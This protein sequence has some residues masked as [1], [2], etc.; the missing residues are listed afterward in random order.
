MS[1]VLPE[2]G[3]S[4]IKRSLLAQIAQIAVLVFI[5]VIGGM[6]VQ[7]RESRLG[8]LE[9]SQVV[10]DSSI[11]RATRTLA[12]ATATLTAINHRLCNIERATHAT[13]DETCPPRMR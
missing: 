4:G 3:R 6:F 12:S 8:S 1:A 7:S 10:Q 2:L 11:S 5:G 13:I 9:A